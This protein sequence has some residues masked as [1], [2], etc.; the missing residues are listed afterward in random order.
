M[1][2]NTN[3]MLLFLGRL[4]S[5]LGDSVFQIGISWYV[6]ELTGSAVLMGSLI[7]VMFFTMIVVGPFAG[8]IVDQNPKVK[9]I[10]WMD[11]IRGV[12]VMG[13]ALVIL[14]SSNVTFIVIILYIMAIITSVCTVVFNPASSALVPLIMSKEELL[15]ANSFMSITGS[16]TSII[17]ILFGGIL[18]G[19]LGAFG[20]LFID[21]ISYILSA[22]SEMFIHAK[23]PKQVQVEKNED[24]IIR[25]QIKIF[26]EGIGYLQD[27]KGLIYIGVFAMFMN[28]SLSPT[29]QIYQPY[30][31]QEILQKKIIVLTVLSIVTSAGMLVGGLFMSLKTTKTDKDKNQLV[32][33]LLQFSFMLVILLSILCGLIFGI[34]K[35]KLGFMSFIILY[36]GIAFFI[37]SFISMINI[38]IETYIQ[39][40]TEPKMMGRVNSVVNTLSFLS[41][42]LGYIICGILVEILSIEYAYLFNTAVLLIVSSMLLWNRH[43][44]KSN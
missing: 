1:I 7:A 10:V 32:D 33:M 2:K 24:S 3:F 41:M 43:K 15:K 42:P 37:G 21:G 25:T 6:L 12:V 9:L 35:F 36:G 39:Q 14:L 23:E 4:V 22:I 19:L 40:N 26:S 29:F 34:M 27:K 16:V 38:P 20:I 18:Y 8:I 13:T 44:I 11:Y 28:F 30:L 5:R 17:G 31:I